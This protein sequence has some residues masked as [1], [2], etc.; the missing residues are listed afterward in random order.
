V[1]ITVFARAP[2]DTSGKGG[3]GRSED[4]V[5]VKDL[6]GLNVST[7]RRDRFTILKEFQTLKMWTVSYGFEFK[8]RNNRVISYVTY[9]KIAITCCY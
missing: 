7:Y 4:Y 8:I 6:E 1:C 2:N 9:K 5:A 3:R